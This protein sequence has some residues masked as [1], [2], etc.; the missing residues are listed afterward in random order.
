MFLWSSKMRRNWTYLGKQ[1]R[2]T[3][4]EIKIFLEASATNKLRYFFTLL[5]LFGQNKWFLVSTEKEKGQSC[6][7]TVLCVMKSWRIHQETPHVPSVEKD[8]ESEVI[9]RQPVREAVYKERPDI[10][11]LMNSFL[12]NWTSYCFAKTLKSFLALYF[13]CFSHCQQICVCRKFLM[14]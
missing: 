7:P 2:C 8:P 13:S 1:T 5:L 14:H 4:R 12:D 6:C 9:C 10:C 11:L 3:V